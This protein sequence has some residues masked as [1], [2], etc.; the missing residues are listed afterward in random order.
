MRLLS[1][2]QTIQTIHLS[3]IYIHIYKYIIHTY[4]VYTKK[5]HIYIYSIL[6]NILTNTAIYYSC[7]LR[8]FLQQ[9]QYYEKKQSSMTNQPV[10][11]RFA[12]LFEFTKRVENRRSICRCLGRPATQSSPRCYGFYGNRRQPGCWSYLPVLLP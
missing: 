10:L 3:Y 4:I 5:T 7:I 9:W 8:F 6:T 2:A 11:F 1:Y 12:Q